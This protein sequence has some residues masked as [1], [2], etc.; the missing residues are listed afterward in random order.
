MAHL[1]FLAEVALPLLRSTAR[2]IT[3][4]P[5][6]PVS[7]CEL[8]WIPKQPPLTERS[9]EGYASDSEA[10]NLER[11]SVSG[12]AVAGLTQIQP[13]H[14]LRE[15]GNGDYSGREEGVADWAWPYRESSEPVPCYL[16]SRTYVPKPDL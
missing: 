9:D 7:V 3:T 13:W 8:R 15:Y 12:R 11:Q 14:L 4:T 6:N 5:A 16:G 1:S 2:S 10:S